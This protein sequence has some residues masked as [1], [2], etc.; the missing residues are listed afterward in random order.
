MDHDNGA[1]CAP[2]AGRDSV[3]AARSEG[4][5]EVAANGSR[6][7]M[8]RLG[9][10]FLMGTRDRDQVSGDGEGPVREVHVSDFYVDTKAV[11]SADY[12]RFVDATGYATEAERF[13]W[14]FVFHHFVSAEVAGNVDQAVAAA[15]WWWRVD[16]AAW[17]SPEGPGSDMDDRL[18][19][20]V[21]HV[22][23]ADASAYAAWAGKR[24]PTEAE[25]ELAAR[26]GLRQ[27]RY[28]WGDTLTPGG[29]HRCNVWQGKFPDVNTGNDGYLGTAPADAFEPNALGTLQHVRQRLGVVRRLVRH[30]PPPRRDR[31]PKGAARGR[32]QGH[33]RRVV[34]VPRLVLQPLPRR[35]PNGVDP[36]QLHR[37]HGFP[38]GDGRQ[39]DRKD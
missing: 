35:R 7:G 2:S 36:G 4:G 18:D 13:G 15:P 1:C 3:A 22:S 9:G 38:P 19:H 27:K 31:G 37:Q 6:D 29:R 28:P 17:F 34:P 39:L 21:V 32:R 5:F 33:Q 10:S 8:V 30:P 25:W 24:L 11:T 14:S 26:G 16:G 12:R 23:W 20:P